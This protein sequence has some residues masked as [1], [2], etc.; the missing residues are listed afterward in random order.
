MGWLTLVLVVF[1]W[2]APALAARCTG[3]A[4]SNCSSYARC[5]A[6]GRW[7]AANPGPLLH[8]AIR[9]GSTAR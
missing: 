3:Q 6:G 7:E 1:L 5:N 9:S 8:P 2:M 4:C